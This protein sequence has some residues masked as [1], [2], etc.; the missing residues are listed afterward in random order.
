MHGT[1]R[2]CTD[3]VDHSGEFYTWRELHTQSAAPKFV[4]MSLYLSASLIVD[5]FHRRCGAKYHERKKFYC[6]GIGSENIIYK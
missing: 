5:I 6:F 2:P 3:S 1:I 4:H